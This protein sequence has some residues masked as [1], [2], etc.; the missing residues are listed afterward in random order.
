MV[1]N[2]GTNSKKRRLELDSTAG[3]S[4][5]SST[6]HNISEA[7]GKPSHKSKPQQRVFP[8]PYHKAFE[9][10]KAKW[11]KLLREGKMLDPALDDDERT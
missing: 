2:G 6:R 4:S 9:K 5:S 1:V 11:P 8:N 10:L 7:R 3:N